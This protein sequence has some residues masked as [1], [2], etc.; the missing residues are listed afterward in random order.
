MNRLKDKRVK[1]S[2]VLDT[3]TAPYYEEG[4]K[5]F[6]KTGIVERYQIPRDATE[7]EEYIY[8][9]KTYYKCM[10][11]IKQVQLVFDIGYTICD[12][13]G[14]IFIKRNFLVKEVFLNM[15]L[16]KHAHYFN[17]YS[18][19]LMM[20]NNNEINIMSWLEILQQI[21][22]DIVMYNIKNIYA[23]N[24][25]FDKK[26]LYATSR[27]INGREPTFFNYENTHFHCLWGMS[28]ETILK[29]KQYFDLAKKE[30]WFTECGNIITKAEHCYRYISNILD[31]EESHTALDDAIIETAI[32]AK[33]L[34]SHQKMSWGIIGM[35]SR[36]VQNYGKERGWI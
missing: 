19:Y 5:R 18:D 33:V 27:V 2:I 17:K 7:I 22:R 24:M 11:S 31:F 34:R 4:D 36:I 23:Y 3:E 6:K 28:C 21:E 26:S 16:M 8:K 9:G 30:N 10:T 32:L 35:P 1:K 14:N 25:S 15:E 20:L 12:N 13:L 29:R